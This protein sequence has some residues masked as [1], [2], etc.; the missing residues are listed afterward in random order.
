MNQG[1]GVKA[2]NMKL[3]ATNEAIDCGDARPDA[4]ALR[5]LNWAL[6]AQARSLS[7]LIRSDDAQTTMMRVCEA[8][9]ASPPYR[10]AY[11]GLAELSLERPIRVIA[12]AG[13]ASDYLDG[14]V[15]SWSVDRPEGQGPAGQTIR[16]GLPMVFND[17]LSAPS[18]ALWRERAEAADLRSGMTVALKGPDGPIGL[19]TV[20]AAEIDAF[21]DPEVTLFQQL[22]DELA[23]ALRIETDRRKLKQA[24]ERGQRIEARYRRLFDH[25]P[26]GLIHFALP[27][28]ADGTGEAAAVIE[29]AN[30]TARALL[31][32]EDGELVGLRADEII[33]PEER[34]ALGQ[35]ME[36]L[37]STPDFERELR[38]LRRDGSVFHASVR[39]TLL[40][41]AEVLA[42]IRDITDRKQ[43]EEALRA[44]EARYRQLFEYAAEGILIGDAVYG[45]SIVNNSFCAMIGRE[46]AEIVG[47]RAREFI[48]EDDRDRFVSVRT[49]IR[50]GEVLEGEV[51]FIRKDGTV[52]PAE[53]LATMTPE[54]GLLTFIR[55]VTKRNQAEEALRVS[56]AR[57]RQLFDYAPDGVAIG[58]LRRG[59]I[60]A[61]PSL[62]RL[63][64]RPLDEIIGHRTNEFVHPD[65]LPRLQLQRE[66]LKPGDV[67]EGEIRMVRKDGALVPVEYVGMMAPD[68][69]L[70]SFL[71]DLT[72]QKEA[73]IARAEANARYRQLFEHALD[74]IVI[75]DSQMRVVDVNPIICENVGYTREEQI[76]RLMTDFVS[77]SDASAAA[78]AMREIAMRNRYL[79]EAS[80][81]RKDGTEYP[82]EYLA[83]LTP[84]GSYLTIVR[85]ITERL[86]AQ[87][88][89]RQSEERYRQIF[90]EAKSGIII[91]KQRQGI[92]DINPSGC[93][94]LGAT[95][96]ELIGVRAVGFMQPV[97]RDSIGEEIAN[98]PVGSSFRGEAQG[99]RRD[100][101]FFPTEFSATVIPGDNVVII[102]DDLTE[103]KAAEEAARMARDELARAGRIATLGE[104]AATISHEINQPLAAMHTNAAAGLRWLDRAP[105]NVAEARV[106]LDR[107]VRDSYRTTEVV[108]RTRRFLA[109]GERVHADFDLNQAIAEVVSLTQAET[110]AAKV[111]VRQALCGQT[112]IIRG[113]RVQIEQ[114]VINLILNAVDAMRTIDDRERILS[115]SVEMLEAG[116]VR[117]NVRDTGD[118][119]DPEAARRVFEPYFTT[120]V[121]GTG[122]GLPISR[123][124]VAAHGGKIWA[125]PAGRHGA[126]F[127]FTL[128]ISAEEDSV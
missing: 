109:K 65:D 92:I 62:G 28:A 96:E 30:A 45:M 119:V 114:V 8:I 87:A 97:D 98:A 104:M 52:V 42:I 15:L 120:K 1:E 54:G 117:V 112:P 2:G 122:L 39:A 127:S 64:G 79:G 48:H 10:L 58:N 41:G 29:V 107:I 110:R 76:G 21:G 90:Q 32:Y 7:A 73:E 43:S 4:D 88:A 99:R 113:D 13:P 67:V 72:R 123:T 18:F 82:V 16:D 19:L 63:L 60:S 6:T 36:S 83:T 101:T 125:E 115:L 46:R 103:R 33:A 56:E 17:L 116:E 81:R 25:S 128:P 91:T 37:R 70:L 22:G 69:K 53:Y 86:E 11:V 108:A 118:G 93:R 85:D 78:T 59:I 57:Y 38:M 100:G 3:S 124:I 74:G 31:G 84:D 5:R 24:E 35:A 126:V 55:N 23:F 12:S 9:V 95:R 26:D 61:N 111:T 77:P 34:A 50:P 102:F 51:R 47:R 14:L 75:S 106:A 49:D 68:G 71:R 44:S 121:S 89:Q 80:V 66:P 105:P 94:M 20:Y 40:P 27:Q